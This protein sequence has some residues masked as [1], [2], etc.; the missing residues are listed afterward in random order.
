[1]GQ[2]YK[3]KSP[4]LIRRGGK[5]TRIIP[6]RNCGRPLRIQAYWIRKKRYKNFFCD[7]AC[8]AEARSLKDNPGIVGGYKNKASGYFYIRVNGV[9]KLKHRVM[10]ERH[11]G[12]E[13]SPREH[14]NHLNGIL[15]DNRIDNLVVVG[16]NDH[17][18]ESLKLIQALQ[19]RIRELEHVQGKM[20]T[21]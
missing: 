15:D 14:V 6:C 3:L 13:L 11:L 16:I 19:R 20:G 12:R 17:P 21:K 1:M 8:E 7:K 2:F 10:M 5:D 9:P 4:S 18:T